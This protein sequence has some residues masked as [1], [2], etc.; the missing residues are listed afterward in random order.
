MDK[1][2]RNLLIGASILI[3]GIVFTVPVLAELTDEPYHIP[4]L[5]YHDEESGEYIPWYPP[6]F[7]PDNPD[8]VPPSEGCPWWDRDGNGEFDWMPHWGRNRIDPEG[9]QFPY[10][11]RNGGC[12]GYGGYRSRGMGRYSKGYRPQ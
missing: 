9:E 6:W 2:T 4:Q 5:Y 12:G 11:R 7:D 3:I 8:T 10:G 1:K